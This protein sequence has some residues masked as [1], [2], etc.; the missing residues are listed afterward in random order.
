MLSSSFP[1]LTHH[2]QYK[3]LKVEDTSEASQRHNIILKTPGLQPS[4]TSDFI[5]FYPSKS[6]CCE[7]TA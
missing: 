3:K 2:E 1:Y 6:Q 4:G 5:E 7:A